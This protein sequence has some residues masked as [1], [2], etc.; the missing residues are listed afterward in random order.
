MDFYMFKKITQA[1]ILS[2][3][4][5]PFLPISANLS[6]KTLI[7]LNQLA[8]AENPDA[9]NELGN[10]FAKGL[11]GEAVDKQKGFDFLLRAA[12]LN[13]PEAQFHVALFYDAGFLGKRDA[14]K[15]AI[16]YKKSADNGFVPALYSL[17]DMY[18]NGDGVTK[19]IDQA[20]IYWKK[21][22]DK[23]EPEA[24]SALGTYFA[25]N[26]NFKEAIYYN[27]LAAKQNHPNAQYN[28]GV[29]YLKGLG[30]AVDE[31][32]ANT[33]FRLACKQGNFPICEN[34]K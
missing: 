7:E 5:F 18:M 26:K 31:E 14:V 9:L 4:I 23:G 33:Y 25:K 20:I 3:L 11:K 16:Y 19:D 6:D 24:Q 29:F 10:I 8:E 15:A 34:I 32:K 2:I 22:S 12:D 13:H 1:I 21:A 30:V 28:L 17:G 27:E